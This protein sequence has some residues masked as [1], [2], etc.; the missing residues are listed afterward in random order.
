MTNLTHSTRSCPWGRTLM[1]L[2]KAALTVVC[3][4]NP[5]TSH[6]EER[7][8]RDQPRSFEIFAGVLGYETFLP[9]RF[10]SLANPRPNEL[11]FLLVLR[12]FRNVCLGLERGEPLDAILPEDFAAYHSSTYLFGPGAKGGGSTTV[13]SPTGDIEKDEDS[14]NPAIFLKPD[15][16]GMTCKIEWRVAEEFSQES[17][18]AIASLFIQWVPWELAL[19]RASPPHNLDQPAFSDAIEWDRPCQG[20]WCP[21]NAFYNLASGEVTMQMTLNITEIEGVRP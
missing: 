11:G 6:G 13:L 10:G 12:M 14:G 3:V 1:A 9:D 5:V 17:Q 16:G 8:I 21:A 18:R 7:S 20:Q 4:L 19:V 2:I 15:A